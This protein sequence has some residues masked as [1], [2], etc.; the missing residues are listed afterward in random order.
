MIKSMT[1]YGRAKCKIEHKSVIIEIKSLNSK[2]LDIYTKLPNLYREKDLELRNL[3]AGS[4]KR[5]KIELIITVEHTGKELASQI[6]PDVIKE[7]Y[8]QLQ[9]INKDLGIEKSE[10]LIQAIMRMPEVLNTDVEELNKEEW[11]IVRKTVKKVINELNIFRE[12]E[13]SVLGRD[14]KKRIDFIESYLSQV[15]DFEQQR[16]ENI[17]KRINNNLNELFDKK[18]IDPARFEQEIIYYLEKIDISEEKTRLKS[19]CNYFLQVMNDNKDGTI[20]KKLGFIAQEA[21]REINTM[22]SKAGDFE[23]QR[24]VVMMK[25]ELEKIKEQ[26]MNI[27]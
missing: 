16:V 4:I 24:L 14:L 10:S 21:G 12:K 2:Q 17:R 22:G 27:Y 15:K 1:G 5:G 8:S 3:I 26:L 20:G 9:R 18:N 7:Y 11:K 25:D 6:N 23:I 13:G 19:H